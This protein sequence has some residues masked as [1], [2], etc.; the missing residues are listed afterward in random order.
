MLVNRKPD[1]KILEGEAC[2]DHIHMLLEILPKHFVLEIMGY[3]TD[4]KYKFGN[5]KFAV[6]GYFV[7]KVG[8]NEKNREYIQNQLQ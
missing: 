7:D 1:L 8:K 6:K 2:Y 3:L 4:I 5:R